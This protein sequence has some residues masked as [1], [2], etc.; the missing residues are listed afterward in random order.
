M[1]LQPQGTLALLGIY[2]ASVIIVLGILT[3]VYGGMRRIMPRV[4]GV[5]VGGK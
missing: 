1:L 2:L 5:I 3:L 4:A